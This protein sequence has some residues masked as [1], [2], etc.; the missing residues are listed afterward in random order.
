[1]TLDEFIT[2]INNR[3]HRE[4]DQQQLRLGQVA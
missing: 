4:Y 3:E 2:W 1:M